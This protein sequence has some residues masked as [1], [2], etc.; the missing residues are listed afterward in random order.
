[1]LASALAASLAA[2]AWGLGLLWALNTEGPQQKVRG[3]AQA[4]LALL[5]LHGVGLANGFIAPLQSMV[6]PQVEPVES[7]LPMHAGHTRAVKYRLVFPHDPSLA[8]HEIVPLPDA[9]ARAWTQPEVRVKADQA[10]TVPFALKISQGPVTVAAQGTLRAAADEGSPLLHYAVGDTWQMERVD[11]SHDRVLFFIPS[12]QEQRRLLRFT[13]SG[14]RETD[15]GLRVRTLTRT[16]EDGGSHA[17]DFVN[18]DGKTFTYPLDQTEL[19]S[20]RPTPEGAMLRSDQRSC[21]FAPLG[22]CRCWATPPDRARTLPGPARC[23]SETGRSS[24]GLDTFV[25]VVTLGLVQHSS[26]Q[27]AYVLQSSHGATPGAGGTP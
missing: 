27:T 8:E 14:E 13:V 22:D 25:A 16:D 9:L 1:V 2:G 18:L 24:S 11:R 23:W 5:W 6:V 17:T 19:I 3:A 26:E 12:N 10:G 20:E 15:E 4:L 21:H 7:K